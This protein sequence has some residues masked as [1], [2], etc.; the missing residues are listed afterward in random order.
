[1]P[2]L[3]LQSRV[4]FF[5]LYAALVVAFGVFLFFE[6]ESRY[7]T[8]VITVGCLFLLMSGLRI[9]LFGGTS[10][11]KVRLSIV[12]ASTIIL[13]AALQAKSTVL[14]LSKPFLEA[15]ATKLN[16][17]FSASTFDV[18]NSFDFFSFTIVVA[19]TTIAVFLL[20][21]IGVS[22]M[23]HPQETPV[24]AILKE[25]NANDRIRTLKSNLRNRLQ[26]INSQTQWSDANYVPLE[27]EVQI[28]EGKSTARRVVDLLKAIRINP[29]TSLF[30]ILG[31]PGTGKSVALRTKTFRLLCLIKFVEVLR[32]ENWNFATSSTCLTYDSCFDSSSLLTLDGWRLF[33]AH[34]R[35]LIAGLMNTF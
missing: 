17:P 4:V 19:W 28:L 15:A 30:V 23:G 34:F 27:A 35:F 14:T 31:E 8:A 10:D 22:A 13:F 29:Q 18:D 33:P 3:D 24:P 20:R 12:S 25:P 32:L 7:A 11:N 26:L 21:N 2:T 16:I 5:L 6:F 9:A 1:M